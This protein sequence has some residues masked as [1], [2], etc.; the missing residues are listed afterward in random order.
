MR[1][2]QTIIGFISL[3]CILFSSPFSSQSFAADF[4]ADYDISYAVSPSGTTIVTQNVTLTNNQ[5]K[6][7]PKQFSIVIDTDKIKNVIAYDNKGVISPKITQADGKTTILLP[8]NE[9]VVGMG[10]TLPFTLRYEHGDIA[11]KYGNIWEINIPGIE[12][13]PT[14][15]AYTVSVQTPPSF[16]SNAYMTPPPSTNRKWTKDQ[17][18]KGG[19]SAAYGNQQDY[20]VNLTYELEN[21]KLTP[22]LY[23]IALPPDTAFQKVQIKNVEPKPKSIRIDDDGNWLGTFQ[24]EGGQKIDV[25]AQLLVSTFIKQRADFQKRII[26]PPNYT[27]SQIFWESEEPVIKKI[28]STSKTAQDIYTFV[29]NKLTYDYNR[30]NQPYVRKGAMG[31]LKEPNTALCSEFTDLFI[32]IARSAGIPAREIVGYAH[33]TNTKLRPLSIVGDVLHAWPEYYDS[34]RNIWVPVDPTWGNT[35]KGIDYFTKLDF[36][37]IAFAIHGLSSETPYP[38]GSYKQG[39]IP[40]KNVI[41]SVSD[42]RPSTPVSSLKTTVDVPSVVTLGYPLEGV[43]NIQNTGGNTLETLRVAIESDP[44]PLT[45]SKTET[46]IPPYGIISIPISIQT[47]GFIPQGKG[48]IVITANG[49]SSTFF[50]DMKP[51]Y[52]L[53]IPA[54]LCIIGGILLIWTLISRKK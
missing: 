29:V 20:S 50:Y 27:K 4:T 44:F 41:V 47:K 33:T 52:W 9:Q 43:V 24:L 36:N 15:G 51:M 37:H 38:A 34:E 54:G 35:T 25:L 13:D 53:L 40:K 5:T 12:N 17:M 2:I 11:S 7:Y 8:F 18:I 31:A 19:I 21:P 30:I 6:L 39:T 26:D 1:Y 49:E 16:G 23:E 10:K 32:A 3:C 28:A 42:V 48:K 14:I 22:V 45:I 46:N